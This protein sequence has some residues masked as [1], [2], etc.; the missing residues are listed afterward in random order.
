MIFVLGSN[1]GCNLDSSKKD[2][3][4]F[5][6]SEIEHRQKYIELIKETRE[7]LAPNGI[8]EQYELNIGGTQQW[9]NV[10]GRDKENPVLLVIHGGPGWP[11]LPLAWNYQ[12]PWED[13]FTVVNW[14]QRGAGKNAI[15]SNHEKLEMTMTLER[16]IQDA[17]EL[18]I[19]LNNKFNRKKIVL[20][21]YSYG[22]RIGLELVKRRPDL[23]EAYVALGQVTSGGEK[24]LYE[25]VF[26]RA[27]KANN[28][29]ALA[30]IKNLKPYPDPDPEIQKEKSHKIREY[31]AKFNGN[32]YGRDNIDLFYELPLLS[33]DY[34]DEELVSSINGNIWF[35][36]ALVKK[37]GENYKNMDESNDILSLNLPIIFLSGKHDLMTPH[38]ASLDLF[39]R[40]QAPSKEFVT[41]ENSAHF[42]MFSQPGLLLKSLIDKVLPH[43]T[44]RTQ[45]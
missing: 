4:L 24:H 18:T 5:T 2:V 8:Q 20:M 45:D 10:R 12:S 40:I 23:F 30:E 43:T 38:L 32:W 21:G 6:D 39:S 3:Q 9:I 31:T 42:I 14:E 33:P 15:T 35:G 25:E 22:T 16:L 34:S 13:V 29:E 1:S 27:E 44:N 7:I 11:Q 28:Q 37:D 36:K 19:H 26:K 41:F 17:E